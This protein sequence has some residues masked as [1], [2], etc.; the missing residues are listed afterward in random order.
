[1]FSYF[2]LFFFLNSSYSQWQA[3]NNDYHKFT[4]KNPQRYFELNGANRACEWNM[5][6]KL[7]FKH[8]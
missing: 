3:N 6:G 8:I 5:I 1:M 7:K 4:Q 2:L